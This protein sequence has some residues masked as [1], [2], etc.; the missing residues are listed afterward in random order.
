MPEIS[1][2]F[3]KR[4]QNGTVCLIFTKIVDKIL[5]SGPDDIFR[6][7][8]THFAN[9]FSIG[10]LSHMSD[11]P[12]FYGL[13]I[14]PHDDFK[15]TIDGDDK[16]AALSPYCLS[17]VRRKQGDEKMNQN[18]TNAFRRINF[19]IGWLGIIPSPLSPFY[20]SYLQQKLKEP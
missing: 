3:L 7:F 5:C 18:G 20:S 1:Q 19:S 17:R 4:D 12:G 10:T 9:V 11:R 13:N 16:S 14:I 8:T 6:R 2:F 15:C